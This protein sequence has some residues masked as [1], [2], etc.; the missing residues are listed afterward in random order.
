V[1]GSAGVTVRKSVWF[2]RADEAQ[3][4]LYRAFWDPVTGV[5]RQ[6]LPESNPRNASPIYWWHAHVMDVLVDA[7]LRTGDR[8][9]EKKLLDMLQAVR[10]YN[11]GT[12]RHYMYDDMEWMALALLRAWDATGTEEYRLAALDLWEDIKTAWN[13]AMGGGMAWNKNKLYYKNTPANCPASILASRLYKRFGDED[14]SAW[15]KRIYDWNK[16][17]L[18]DPETGFVWDGINR[19][20]DGRIDKDWR[21]T[22]CQGVFIGAAVELYKNT[23][24]ASY[25]EDS[26]RTARASIVQFADSR[27]GLLPNE[28]DGDCGLFKGIYVR[29]LMGLLKANPGLD[30]IRGMLLKNA[31]ILWNSGRDRDTGLFGLSWDRKPGPTPDLS[32]HLSGIMLIEIASEVT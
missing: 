15:A 17:T 7:L 32:A 24:D 20:G 13:P 23:G 18:V 3:R 12:L 5:M 16:T 26:V 14:N 6:G 11:G 10:E 29:Y 9:Y 2:D 25:L 8:D 1:T 28:G 21:F 22:Y 27:T 30:E 19:L 31:D 4:L